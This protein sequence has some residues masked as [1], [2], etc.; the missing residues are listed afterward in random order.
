[1]QIDFGELQGVKDKKYSTMKEV[2]VFPQTFFKFK[3]NKS[4]LQKSLNLVKKEEY[5]KCSTHAPHANSR[6][7]NSTLHKKKEYN[8]LTNWVYDCIDEV[9]Q[10]FRWQC[11]KF[12]ITQFWSNKSG[13]N[14]THHQH[15]HPNSFLSGILYLSDSDART[16]F[17]A[18][19]IWNY[20]NM[21][22]KVIQISPSDNPE[23]T[24]THKEKA[25][26]GKLIIFPSSI[27]HMVEPN[28][29]SGTVIVPE[30]YTMSWNA[31]PSG[32]IGKMSFL[33]GL[34]IEIK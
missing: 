7:T 21:Q 16:W 15:L 32:K 13:Y 33:S 29:T 24:I 19:N 31:F 23:L 20:F 2:K 28:Q 26:A 6:S 12:T 1:M 14:E 9:R 18:D 4:L 22:N 8:E 10:H 25:E 30:R 17:A 34:D 5:E 27:I 11:E 3:C